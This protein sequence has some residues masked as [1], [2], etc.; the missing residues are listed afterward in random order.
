M[1]NPE[2]CL[3]ALVGWIRRTT[4]FENGR[5]VL[6]PI[7]GGS[8]SALCFRL[9]ALALPRERV[10]GAYVGAHLRCRAW[11][12]EVGTVRLLAAPE[13]SAHI[14]AQRWAMMLSQSLEVRGWLVGTRNRTEETL[15]TYS[16]ASRMATYLPLANLWKSEVME[17][18]EYAGVPEEVLQSSRRADPAC[19]RP[20]EI[21]DIPFEMV[22]RF[23]QVQ[24]G[25][26]PPDDLTAIPTAVQEYLYR[27][28]RRNRFKVH[29]PLRPPPDIQ[30][31][32]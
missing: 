14:E 9:C 25:E 13:G 21:A 5:G 12:E 29:L 1:E 19:G 26:R 6:V 23:L 15:G 27:L 2:A 24:V 8:D 30:D 17:L 32:E 10:F 7:S 16:L 28:Y 11:F 18:A 22:D 3:Q 31:T 4:D 20:Q